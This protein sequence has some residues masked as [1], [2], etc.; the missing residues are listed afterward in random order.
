[1]LDT[2]AART[3]HKIQSISLKDMYKNIIK[4]EWFAVIGLLGWLFVVF[5][6]IL[7]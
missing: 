7:H 5:T 3:A 2:V 1:M 6:A 4:L